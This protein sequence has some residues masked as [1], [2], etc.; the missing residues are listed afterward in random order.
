MNGTVIISQSI[1]RI[2][3]IRISHEAF[4][5]C[6]NGFYV[7]I[8]CRNVLIEFKELG[9]SFE[10][11]AM[12][13]IFDRNCYFDTVEFFCRFLVSLLYYRNAFY[14]KRF[15][16]S[17]DLILERFYI[18]LVRICEWSFGSYTE[19]SCEIIIFVTTAIAVCIYSLDAFV[20]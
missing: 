13:T 8:A 3:F 11:V 1:H 20:I 14:E 9:H 2:F 19:R 18:K 12:I 15:I 7:Y 17:F 5:L 10:E 4:E 6:S 16:G